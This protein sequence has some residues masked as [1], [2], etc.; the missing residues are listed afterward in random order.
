M[1]K[2]PEKFEENMK[3]LL[4][5]DYQK[6]VKSMEKPAKRGLRVNSEY[7]LPEEFCKLFP[8]QIKPLLNQNNLFCLETD[9]KIGNSVFHHAGMIYLQEPSSMLAVLALDV[10]DGENILDLCAAP[11]G[12]TGQILEKDKTGIVVSNEVVRARANVLLSNIERQGFKNSTITSLAPDTLSGLLPDFF[13]KILVDA[14]CSGE[15]MFRKEPETISEWNSGLPEFNHV[16]Q[17]QILK[18][19]DK[20]LKHGGTL[21]YSTC[22][23]NRNEDEET[24]AVFAKEYGYEIVPLP[25]NVQSVTT[26][27][28]DVFDMK[29]SFARK[30][31]PFGDFG[32]GQFVCKMKK[33]SE[34]TCESS[35]LGKVQ[36]LSK[37]EIL[38]AKQLLKST[39]DDEEFYFYKL[40]DNVYISKIPLRAVPFGVVSIGVCLGELKKDRI[41][42]AHHF[43]KAFGTEFKNK[44]EIQNNQDA[45]NKYLCGNEIECDNKNG[46]VVV[47]F[48]GVPLGG[49]KVVAG[50]VKN[51]YPKGLRVSGSQSNRQKL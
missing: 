3:S 42:P 5:E 7:I 34:N 17:L 13:D 8:Y 12:K 50:R 26:A 39:I 25:E 38:L 10:K 51:Y 27:G 44:I 31:F 37:N 11:G 46:L 36:G 28:E 33:I 29:T 18:E 35:R 24:V 40:G 49:G 45:L 32:E 16:R 23:F 14:P 48:H 43:F 41:E 22:T 30:C 6:Y 15:G 4:K 19:A 9:E 20:M 21:I 1:I 47:L 2:L